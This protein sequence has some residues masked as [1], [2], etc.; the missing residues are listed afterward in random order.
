MK[1]KQLFLLILIGDPKLSAITNIVK[2]KINLKRQEDK[3]YWEVLTEYE[4]IMSK[5]KAS[6]MIIGENSE[7][8]IEG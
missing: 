7:Y 4:M 3:C 6:A 2:E 1:K 5:S 8:P